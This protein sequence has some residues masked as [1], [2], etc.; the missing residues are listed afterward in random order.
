ME[1]D[2]SSHNGY[3]EPEPVEDGREE[4]WDNSA[5]APEESRYSINLIWAEA[6]TAEGA[7]GAIGNQGEM[8]WHLSEDLKRFADLTVSHPVIMGRR[9]WESLGEKYR[10]LRNRD[11]IVVS[12]NPHYK[13]V[14]ASVVESLEEALGIAREEAIPDDGMDRSEIWVIGGGTIFKECLALA[15]RAFV[16]EI[17][18]VVPADVFAPDI[19]GLVASG[20]WERAD[21][22]EW[23]IPA[24]DAD[25]ISR[26]RYVRYDNMALRHHAH[27]HE[28]VDARHFEFEH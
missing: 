18:A 14:G 10:P 16:T 6:K 9:T 15:S 7:P 12:S 4:F 17:D 28:Q 13:A 24:K 2:S 27:S 19:R 11:N 26:Y 8:P 23:R 21:V 3:H 5:M 20:E 1:H 25:T 22:G